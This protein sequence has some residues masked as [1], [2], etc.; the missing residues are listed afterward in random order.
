MLLDNQPLNWQQNCSNVIAS[1][2]TNTT[3]SIITSIASATIVIISLIYP[4]LA[5]ADFSVEDKNWPKQLP[6]SEY[7]PHNYYGNSATNSFDRAVVNPGEMTDQE[8]AE[9]A[10]SLPESELDR[11]YIKAG[12]FSRTYEVGSIKNKSLGAIENAT[13]VSKKAKKDSKALLL[14]LGKTW[15]KWRVD[16]EYHF[17]QKVNYDKTQLFIGRA[18]AITSKVESS[19]IVATAY[20]DFS[21][22]YVFKPFVGLSAGLGFNT[23]TATLTGGVGTGQEKKK[24]SIAP[25]LGLQVGARARVFNTKA[26]IDASYRYLNLGKAK[27][28]DE[29][30]LLKLEGTVVASGFALSLIYLW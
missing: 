6:A 26:F 3:I 25:A 9:I 21:E 2:A 16:G 17:N 12:I 14:G 19:N 13:L 28:V 4:S 15:K 8:R 30:N 23:V 18:E 22:L 24:R 29:S 10:A 7:G 11:W 27:W 20:Y 1:A 5:Q